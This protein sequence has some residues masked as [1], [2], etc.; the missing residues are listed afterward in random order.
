MLQSI[1]DKSQGL[2]VGFIVF[3]ISLTFALFGIQ[4]YFTGQD[5]VTV[6]EV[7]SQKIKL[8]A[9]LERIKKLRQQTE[10][11]LGIQPNPEIWS[12]DLIKSQTLNLMIDEVVLNQVIN[13]SGIRVSDESIVSRI[14]DI[15]AFYDESG[16]SR[17]RYESLL[18]DP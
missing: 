18:A 16:F 17:Q 10:E 5:D 9:L 7:D 15:D 6:A 13:E 11:E 1:R 3:L 4:S 2:I 8:T 14:K 12:S